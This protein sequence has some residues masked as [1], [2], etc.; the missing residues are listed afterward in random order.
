MKTIK[1]LQI[2]EL[3]LN[4]SPRGNYG[5]CN[6][7]ETRFCQSALFFLSD[8]HFTIVLHATLLYT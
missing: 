4:P 7:T 3:E 6:G 5:L 1:S 2:V 8:K